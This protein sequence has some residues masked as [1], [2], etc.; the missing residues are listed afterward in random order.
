MDYFIRHRAVEKEKPK[1]FEQLA[2]HSCRCCHCQIIYIDAETKCIMISH[3]IFLTLSLGFT[4]KHGKTLADK[5]HTYKLTSRIV[6]P[7]LWHRLHKTN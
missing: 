4:S 6:G 2:S 3:Y 5:P 1:E 7:L